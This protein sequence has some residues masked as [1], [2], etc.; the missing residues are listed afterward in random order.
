MH[1]YNLDTLYG[2]VKKK[3]KKKKNESLDKKAKG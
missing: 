3:K 2:K 1:D